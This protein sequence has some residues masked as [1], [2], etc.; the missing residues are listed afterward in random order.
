MTENSTQ[1]RILLIEDSAS[2][3][4]LLNALLEDVEE[5]E[6]ITEHVSELRTALAKIESQQ[7]DAVILDLGLPDSFG[8]ETYDQVRER[9][10]LLPII[11]VSG[12]D[13]RSMMNDALNKGADNYLL[14]ESFDGN[15]IAV[16]ILSAIRR[17]ASKEGGA[18]W[19]DINQGSERLQ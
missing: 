5:L 9:A 8:V 7:Y 16:A 17:K 2:D 14:K 15:R 12:N 11:I 3:A 1:L 4:A 6:F 18:T 13:D 10:P 19:I